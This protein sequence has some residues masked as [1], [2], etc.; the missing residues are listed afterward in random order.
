MNAGIDK[1]LIVDFQSKGNFFKSTFPPESIIPILF[2]ENS[3]LF[4]KR[5]ARAV[6]EEG[7]TI[8]FIRSQINFIALIIAFRLQ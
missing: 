3:I 1:Q 2:P 4:S 8:I 7:S 6:A 5:M